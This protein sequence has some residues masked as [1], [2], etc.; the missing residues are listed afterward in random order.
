G[1]PVVLAEDKPLLAVEAFKLFVGETDQNPA[2]AG[3]LGVLLVSLTALVLLIQRRYLGRRRF[4][5]GARR[6]PPVR[7][8]GG[9]LRVAAPL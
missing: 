3:V 5:T 8:V 2:S 6:S 7:A 4:A 1:V 9:G